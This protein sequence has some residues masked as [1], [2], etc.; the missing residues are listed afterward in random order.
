MN[1]QAPQRKYLT[2]YFDNTVVDAN[3]S[4]SSPQMWHCMLNRKF[5]LDPKTSFIVRQAMLGDAA[6]LP[7]GISRCPLSRAISW[8]TLFRDEEQHNDRTVL[9]HAGVA[10]EIHA[11]I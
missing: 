11:T 7:A 9:F 2:S 10:A 5:L 1:R 8:R 3:A 6:A 4:E